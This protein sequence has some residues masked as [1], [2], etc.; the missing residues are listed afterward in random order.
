MDD[1]AR[2]MTWIK[3][4]LRTC[5]NAM[6]RSAHPRHSSVRVGSL[7]FELRRKKTR[8]KPQEKKNEG[9]PCTCDIQIA[10]V[11]RSVESTPNTPVTQ[12]E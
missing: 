3:R 11:H 2:D 12:G 4:R 9:M 7:E 1:T 6:Q 10:E 5:A 8:E